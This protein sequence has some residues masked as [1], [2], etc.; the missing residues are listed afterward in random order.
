MCRSTFL[1]KKYCFI[2]ESQSIKIHYSAIHAKRWASYR[3]LG[4]ADAC[5]ALK[6]LLWWQNCFCACKIC[7]SE[8]QQPEELLCHIKSASR[9][10]QNETGKRWCEKGAKLCHV[11]TVSTSGHSCYASNLG[12]S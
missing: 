12:Q 10:A 11:Q 8:I 5:F 3:H 9:K 1:Q 7:F 2:F 6:N 4:K